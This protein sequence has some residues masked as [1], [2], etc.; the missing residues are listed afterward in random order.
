MEYLDFKSKYMLLKK[1]SSIFSIK[2]GDVFRS[3]SGECYK[4]SGWFSILYKIYLAL[5]TSELSLVLI[6]LLYIFVANYIEAWWLNVITCVLI[7]ILIEVV[8][9]ALIPLKKVPCWEK[10]LQDKERR[11]SGW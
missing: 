7:Y 2:T 11:E 5:L 9:I 3:N 10:S 8:F 6:F 4:V 1:F